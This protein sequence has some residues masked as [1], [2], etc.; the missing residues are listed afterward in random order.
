MDVLLQQL[1]LTAGF[2][3]GI[4]S[5]IKRDHR[6]V[7]CAFTHTGGLQAQRWNT[8]I[9]IESGYEPKEVVQGLFFAEFIGSLAVIGVAE[10]VRDDALAQRVLVQVKALQSVT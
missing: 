10:V 1:G 6:R 4:L 7:M 3:E 8:D 2:A 9:F 5:Q